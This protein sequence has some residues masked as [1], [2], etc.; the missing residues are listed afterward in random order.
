MSVDTGEKR[1]RGIAVGI[2][3]DGGL[4]LKSRDG[5]IKKILNGDVS[6]TF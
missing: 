6:I 3:R 5:D 4:I 1:E 2:D